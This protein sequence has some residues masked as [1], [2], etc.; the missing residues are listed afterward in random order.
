MPEAYFAGGNAFQCSDRPGGT[1]GAKG[2]SHK[3]I[4]QVK[5]IHTFI[6]KVTGNNLDPCKSCRRKGPIP[7]SG[8]LLQL[9]ALCC[10]L[11]RSYFV[12]ISFLF[13]SYFVLISFSFRSYFVLISF[14]FRSYFVL[15][16]FLFRSYI[17][18]GPLCDSVGRSAIQ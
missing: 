6:R 13:R 5:V 4:L 2:P 1:S 16:S 18:V 14:L 10:S 11:R 8:T 12:L 15:I 17:S 9:A 7:V 3:F